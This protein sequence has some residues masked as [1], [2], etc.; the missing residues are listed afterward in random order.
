M[1]RITG[2]SKIWQT[3]KPSFTDKTLKDEKITFVEGGKDITKEKDLVKMFKAQF[4]K[5]VDTLKIDRPILY[6]L[7]DDPVLNAIEK[8]CHHSSV[9]KIKESRNS[10]DCFSFKLV[11]IEDICNEIRALNASKATQSDDMPI[12][13]IKI[14]PAFFLDFFKRILTMLLKQVLFQ[15]N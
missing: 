13:I 12:K 5:M 9:L 14:T 1:K 7:S 6:D 8:F 15:S 4:E 10:S 11:T 3:I 2:N